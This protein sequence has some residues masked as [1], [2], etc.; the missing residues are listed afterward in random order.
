[1]MMS[2]LQS[3]SFLTMIQ[4]NVILH[5]DVFSRD[6]VLNPLRFSSDLF[7]FQLCI[8]DDVAIHE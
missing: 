7:L 8:G 2:Q 5:C 6:F 3:L 4:M 1:M